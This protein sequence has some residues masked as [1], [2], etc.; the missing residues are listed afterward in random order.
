MLL[1]QSWNT[2][3]HENDEWNPNFY[4]QYIRSHPEKFYFEGIKEKISERSN[5]TSINTYYG[6]MFM[7]CL[8]TIDFLN[9][10]YIELNYQ[11]SEADLLMDSLNSLYKFHNYPISY[12]YNSFIYY[13]NKFDCNN[14]SKKKRFLNILTCKFKAN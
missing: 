4:A 7:R 3:C 8:P 12:V 1:L 11:S 5:E 13:N 14:N 10:R 6:N 9:N 2:H